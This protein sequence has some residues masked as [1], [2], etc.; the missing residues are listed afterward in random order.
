LRLCA[1]RKLGFDP[2]HLFLPGLLLLVLLLGGRS[3]GVPAA[4]KAEQ[5]LVG[6]AFA[7]GFTP[8]NVS[9]L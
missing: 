6:G 8:A 5:G 7:A 1:G 2:R 3:L 4:S 9:V